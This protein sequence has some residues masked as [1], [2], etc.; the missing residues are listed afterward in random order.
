MYRSEYSSSSEFSIE[1]DTG[2]IFT[3]V[4]Y[5]LVKKID[6][7]NVTIPTIKDNT[8][9]SINKSILTV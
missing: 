8:F 6:N 3:K 7:N 4:D 2:S 5:I 1:V 9:I